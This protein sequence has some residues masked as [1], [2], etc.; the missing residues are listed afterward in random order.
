MVFK[1]LSRDR[2]KL[3]QGFYYFRTTFFQLSFFPI[4]AEILRSP[5]KNHKMFQ[6]AMNI[7]RN[8]QIR[9]G[10]RKHRPMKFL[11]SNKTS[12]TASQGPWPYTVLI[13]TEVYNYS[14]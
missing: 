2:N 11:I 9:K 8:L 5:N 12:A 13:L 10:S 6:K 7:L 4:P 1:R 3:L 14:E